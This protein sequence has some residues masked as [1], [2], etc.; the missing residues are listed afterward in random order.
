MKLEY[1]PLLKDRFGLSWARD[2]TIDGAKYRVVV[3]AGRRVRLAYSK[4]F[5]YH[6]WAYV[7]R[8]GVGEVAV[9]PC[10]KSDGVRPIVEEALHR[11]FC[12]KAFGIYDVEGAM[13]D[14]A[15]PPGRVTLSETPEKA[16]Y[17]RLRKLHYN[18]DAEAA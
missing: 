14:R 3:K 7:Y 11:E 10:N 15:Y 1:G 18:P 4:K 5:G 2:L 16:A 13:Y 6:W 17:H 9:I 8:T 12:N